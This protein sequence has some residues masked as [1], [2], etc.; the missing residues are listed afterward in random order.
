ML[1]QV[2]CQTQVL[3]PCVLRDDLFDRFLY[4]ISVD[5]VTGVRLQL[6][7]EARRRQGLD[8]DW[9]SPDLERRLL[10]DDTDDHYRT[11]HY[12]LHY[13]QQPHLFVRSCPLPLPLEV[14]RRLVL[15]FYQLDP[16][17]CRDL[18]GMSAKKL[19]EYRARGH[20]QRLQVENVRNVCKQ[21]TKALDH[22]HHHS[23]RGVDDLLVPMMQLPGPA[24][25]ALSPHHMDPAVQGYSGRFARRSS[26]NDEH[27][28][29]DI[30]RRSSEAHWSAFHGPRAAADAT[31]TAY[32]Q[33]TFQLS[34]DLA[35]AYAVLCFSSRWT[36]DTGRRKKGTWGWQWA[37]LLHVTRIMMRDW[38]A[39]GALELDQ[40]LL[41]SLKAV[42]S[43]LRET[44][45]MDTYVELICTAL[46]DGKTPQRA[47][48]VRAALQAMVDLANA[49]GTRMWQ[50]LIVTRESVI[51]PLMHTSG[52]QPAA[53]LRA[54]CD[55]PLPERHAKRG[56][57]SSLT[58]SQL[59]HW[60]KFV[61]VLRAA[62]ERASRTPPPPPMP[63]AHTVPDAPP[64]AQP[65]TAAAAAHP[66]G[67][68]A[69]HLTRT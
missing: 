46:P 69:A 49:L 60:L 21:V 7:R 29:D 2:T 34:D 13:L 11:F 67:P 26:G 45:V 8:L 24:V 23:G 33:S 42:R 53:V 18:Y 6:A 4:G 3:D 19:K 14:R 64:P 54:V 9:P 41:E 12:L 28:F 65:T 38:T 63:R 51:D 44:A 55:V 15:R 30:S 59:R 66:G 68:M 47:K 37:D 61:G 27:R 48:A 25:D 40:Q 36:I 20:P 58:P 31:A 16:D 50:A 17:L 35:E 57:R 1:G 43:H 62:A 10:R 52:C 5:E 32:V 22:L 39:A 56:C